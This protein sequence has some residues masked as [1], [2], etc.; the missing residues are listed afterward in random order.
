MCLDSHVMIK[1]IY[2]LKYMEWRNFWNIKLDMYPLE[3]LRHKLYKL[4]K[5]VAMLWIYLAHN[6]IFVGRASWF[7]GQ[8]FGLET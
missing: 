8:Q 7:V 5:K 4:R 6:E 2:F 3:L 1:K